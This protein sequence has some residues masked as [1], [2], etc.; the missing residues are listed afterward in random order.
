MHIL[1]AFIVFPSLDDEDVGIG[2]FSKTSR[3]DT[4]SGASSS[5]ETK[6]VCRIQTV[7]ATNNSPANDIIERYIS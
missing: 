1:Q 3:D 2:V 4:A 6:S 5:R 7:A